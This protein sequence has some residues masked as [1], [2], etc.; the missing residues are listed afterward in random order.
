MNILDKIVAAKRLEVAERKTATPLS[1]LIQNPNMKEPPHS[2]RRALRREGSTGII[3]EH[4][5]KSPSLGWIREHSDVRAVVEGYAAAGAAA[6]S[7]LT[8]AAFFGGSTSDLI[9]ARRTVGIP[10][11]RKDFIIDEYQI[12]EAKAMGAD[13]ILLIAECLSK[14]EIK[15]LAETA[16]NIGLEILL[17]MHDAEGLDKICDAV[18]CVG[19]NNRNLKTFDVS[20]QTSMDLASQIPSAFVK[21]AESG[22]SDPRSIAILRGHGFEG[23]LIGEA[24]MKT[25][26]PSSAIR[27][28]VN[29]LVIK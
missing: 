10:I 17:E 16:R 12:F 8:D 26:D 2:L 7:V 1:N 24:F 15:N 21:I 23:F 3:A 13:V 6:L 29:S 11:L 4:K 19:V 9:A 25:A 14:S 5:R 18:S 28:F 20:L 22:I 27:D